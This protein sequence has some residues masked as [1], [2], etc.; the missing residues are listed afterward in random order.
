[1][2][3]SKYSLSKYSFKILFKK[4]GGR[5]TGEERFMFGFQHMFQATGETLEL[6][7]VPLTL[8]TVRLLQCHAPDRLF[9]PLSQAH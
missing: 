2:C 1:M 9:L 5:G 6:S 8:R 3:V 7:P 4:G